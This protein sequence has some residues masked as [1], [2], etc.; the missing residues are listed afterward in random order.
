M[1]DVAT[2][3]GVLVDDAAIQNAAFQESRAGVRPYE[4]SK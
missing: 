2:P 1:L 4:Q 3:V